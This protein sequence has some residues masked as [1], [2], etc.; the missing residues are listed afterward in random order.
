[1]MRGAIQEGA[2]AR[3]VTIH[4]LP[5][6]TRLS[7]ASSASLNQ[8]ACLRVPGHEMHEAYLAAGALLLIDEDLTVTG[9]DEMNDRAWIGSADLRLHAAIGQKAG[10][11][12]VNSGLRL[13]GT[14][15]QLV[16]G[17]LPLF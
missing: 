10:E 3:A 9:V 13:A 7:A 12:D 11:G 6:S 16:H 1:M 5:E 2:P 17:F 15:L 14:R 4:S 8:L